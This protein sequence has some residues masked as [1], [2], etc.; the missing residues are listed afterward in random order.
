MILMTHNSS[1]ISFQQIQ[2]VYVVA[3][4][5]QVV[6]AFMKGV[7]YLSCGCR[8]YTIHRRPKFFVLPLTPLTSFISTRTAIA[9]YKFQRPR[10]LRATPSDIREISGPSG[11]NS[12]TTKGETPRRADISFVVLD[13]EIA[14]L[15]VGWLVVELE[16]GLF[17]MGVVTAW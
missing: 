15:Y 12:K 4:P 13:P 10:E 6:L 1:R 17:A 8:P 11:I 5:S 14:I 7:D 16:E 9:Y 3:G 2:A